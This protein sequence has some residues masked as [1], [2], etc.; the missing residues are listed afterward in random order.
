MGISK[1]IQNEM[2]LN[3]IHIIELVLV[4]IKYFPYLF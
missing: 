3:G 1:G 2:E 4:L